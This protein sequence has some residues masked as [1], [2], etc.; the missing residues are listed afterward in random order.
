MIEIAKILVP[1]DFSETAKKALAYASALAAQFK[2]KLFVAHIVP[3]SSALSYAFPTET[4]KIEQNQYKKA[5]DELREILPPDRAAAVDLKTISKIGPIDREL[6]EIVRDEAIGLVVMGRHGRRS[7][8]RWFLGSVTEKILRQVPVPV[9]TV[10]HV[11]PGKHELE[12]GLKAIKRILYAADLPEANPA[13]DY[14]FELAQRTGAELTVVNVIEHLNL[15]YGIA[16][17]VTGEATHRVEEMRDRF[18]EFLVSTNARGIHIET[19]IRDGKPYEEILR[20]AE[21]GGMDMIVL[22]MH[23][24]G[25]IER[26]F[27]GSTAERIVRLAHVPV[28]SVPASST[29]FKTEST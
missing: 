24:K 11:G 15:M 13:M 3:E 26:A 2:S 22:N 21:A 14:A 5:M 27:L 9:L 6:L 20:V 16:E 1:V 10:P 18:H 4:F 23:S 25:V 17:H 29:S 7:V 12:S 28:L 8:G 19:V